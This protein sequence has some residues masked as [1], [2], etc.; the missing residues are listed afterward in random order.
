MTTLMS[1]ENSI[2]R[3][4]VRKKHSTPMMALSRILPLMKPE[5]MPLAWA[6]TVMS[7]LALPVGR[8]A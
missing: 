5:K 4:E 3:S 6:H 2:R 1:T 8:T 7:R